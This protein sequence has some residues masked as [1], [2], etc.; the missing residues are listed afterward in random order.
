MRL[1]KIQ[2]KELKELTRFNNH[3]EARLVL[4]CY[5]NHHGLKEAYRNIENIHKF[6]HS[7]PHHLSLLRNDLDAIL[8]NVAAHKIK[9]FDKVHKCF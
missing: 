8:F 4:A 9:N 5:I 6:F 3:T 2:L 7:M 1:N